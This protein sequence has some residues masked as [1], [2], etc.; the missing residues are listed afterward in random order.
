MGVQGQCRHCADRIRHRGTGGQL[1]WVVRD[2]AGLGEGLDYEA[3]RYAM[4]LLVL[5]ILFVVLM[6]LLFLTT[7]YRLHRLDR[8]A[9][10]S[11]RLSYIGLGLAATFSSFAVLFWNHEPTLVE[12]TLGAAYVWV[13]VAT[14]SAWR[15]KYPRS[16][17]THPTPLDSANVD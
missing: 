17:V 3:W 15:K 2:C 4:T 5:D 11:V 7:F 9:L 14:Q 10:L 1:A 12:F 6:A 13:Q 16:F 8:T